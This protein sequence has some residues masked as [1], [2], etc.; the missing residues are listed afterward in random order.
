[1]L[2]DNDQHYCINLTIAKRATMVKI[3]WRRKSNLW[4]KAWKWSKNLFRHNSHTK[5]TPHHVEMSIYLL[6]NWYEENFHDPQNNKN[7]NMIPIERVDWFHLLKVSQKSLIFFVQILSIFR[8]RE[9]IEENEKNDPLIHAVEKK[10][11]PWAEKGK[12][13]IM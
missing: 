7:T 13:A 2:K 1:M 12:C 9:F 4:G 5:L 10:N 3:M 8:M 6:I 11:N